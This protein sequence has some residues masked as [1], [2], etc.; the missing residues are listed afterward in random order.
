[1]VRKCRIGAGDGLTACQILRFKAF[2]I[3]RQGEFGLGA[4]RGGAGL[5]G[6]QGGGHLAGVAGGDVDV[7]GLQHA[8][9]VGF[10]G[11][12]AAQPLE[13]G[14]LIAEGFQEGEGEFSAVEGLFRQGGD[15]FLYLN[16]VHK[17]LRSGGSGSVPRLRI[18]R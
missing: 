7:V 2:A 11:S 6:V 3:G 9:Q 14:F 16:S 4:G 12:P 5:Q 1:M 15:G 8:A 13:R 17:V 10:I 18:S